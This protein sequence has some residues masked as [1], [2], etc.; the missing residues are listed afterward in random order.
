MKQIHNQITCLHFRDQI[1]HKALA[2]TMNVN[3]C[4]EG[5][6]GMTTSHLPTTNYFTAKQT[7]QNQNDLLANHPLNKNNNK[8]TRKGAEARADALSVHAVLDFFCSFFASR[9][10]RKRTDKSKV[11]DF[12]NKPTHSQ[13]SPHQIK[14]STA[15]HNFSFV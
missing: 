13:Y 14:N 7:I 4:V 8:A 10:K 3:A 15:K 9:Q 6:C 11:N 1:P 12:N 2:V 5:N